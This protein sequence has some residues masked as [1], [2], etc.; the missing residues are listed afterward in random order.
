MTDSETRM[1]GPVRML[2]VSG[3]AA[4][5]LILREIDRRS[6][7]IFAFC[8]MHTFNLANKSPELVAALD[9]ARVFNDGIGIDVASRI[10]NGRPFPANLN[11][12]D[13]TPAVLDALLLPTN[14]FLLGSADGVAERAGVVLAARHPNVVVVGTH[15][16]FLNED[17]APTLIAQIRAADTA[18]LLLGMGNPR[19]ELWAARYADQAGA[20]VMCIGAFLDF[21]AGE[22]SRAPRI[23]QQLRCEWVYRMALEPRRMVGRYLGGAVPFLW[24]VMKERA[25]RR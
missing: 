11:G 6:T 3:A 21:T 9:K 5:G 4:V 2:A 14:V 13:L 23:V 24:A 19:Q 16:G 25:T 15:H 10:L 12:T 8:N 17:D 18:L 22:V 20:A 7:A 1:I